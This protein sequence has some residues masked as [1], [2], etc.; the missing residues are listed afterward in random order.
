MGIPGDRDRL[1]MKIIRDVE[2]SAHTRSITSLHHDA[3]M[4]PWPPEIAVP[5]VLDP[6]RRRAES[7][8]VAGSARETL[9]RSITPA[10]FGSDMHLL[11]YRHEHPSEMVDD[12][13]F[14][15]PLGPSTLT[16]K[17]RLRLEKGLSIPVAS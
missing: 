3:M 5:V 10:G 8:V 16:N 2:G 15:T 11:T 12:G 1:S 4:R 14:P 13:R 7:P 6:P 17:P 9:G